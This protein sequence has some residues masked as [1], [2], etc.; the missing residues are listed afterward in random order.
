MFEYDSA[1]LSC[2]VGVVSVLRQRS[3]ADVDTAAGDDR[4]RLEPEAPGPYGSPRFPWTVGAAVTV[5]GADSPIFV[6]PAENV[7]TVQANTVELIGASG[8]VTTVSGAIGPGL[9]RH[10]QRH[11]HRTDDR[12]ADVPESAVL[13]VQSHESERR[14][15]AADHASTAAA[16]SRRRRLLRLRPRRGSHRRGCRAGRRESDRCF[17][18]CRRRGRTTTWS[19]E[20]TSGASWTVVAP[21]VTTTFFVDSGLAYSTTY[22]YCVVAVAASGATAPSSVVTAETGRQPDVLS[23][24]VSSLSLT[25]G[26]LVRRAGRELH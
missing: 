21:S 6:D 25:R 15:T 23:V 5:N 17:L 24:G 10:R 19:S 22:S 11:C 4:Q 13:S 16:S 14:P 8:A 7:V 9:R 2:V 3:R 1:F 26:S 18:E 20:A 12:T